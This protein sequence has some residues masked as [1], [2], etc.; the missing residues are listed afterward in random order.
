MK[1]IFKPD[2]SDSVLLK[3]HSFSFDASVWEFYLPLITGGKLV[4]AKPE[5]HMDMPYLTGNYN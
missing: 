5:G 3:T 1:E 4:V 2:E